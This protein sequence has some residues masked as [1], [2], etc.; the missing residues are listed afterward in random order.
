[1]KDLL[2]VVC[3]SVFSANISE[4]SLAKTSQ[5]FQEEQIL[6]VSN[7]AEPKDLDPGIATGIPEGHIIDTLFQGL[8]DVGPFSPDPIPGMAESWTISPDGLTY[9]F[10]IRKDA[11]WSDGQA[12]TADDFV[13]SWRR[14]LD[15]KTA[16]EY[17]YQLYYIKNGEAFN[18]GQI[19]DANQLGVHAKDALTLEVVL[20][21]PTP[22]FLQLTSFM[23]LYPVPKHVL[24]KYSGSEWTKENRLVSNGAFKLAEYR[25][26]QHIKLVKNEHFWDKA[27]IKPET[28]YI[29]PIENK[30][31]EEK[32]F[33]SGKIH[34]TSTVPAMRLPYYESQARENTSDH[35]PLK[36]E[37][38]FGT[39]YYRFNTSKK[40]LNDPR[41]RRALTLTVDRKE[42]VD[43]I[44]RGGKVPA[45]SFT[46]PLGTFDFR[47]S[48]PT[49][50]TDADLQE[51]KT[52]L[53]QAGYPEGKNMPKLN[54]LY[55][56][57]EDNKRIAIAIQDMWHKHL[58]IKV[59]IY[60]EEWKV[61]LESLRQLNFDI[62]RSRWIGDY[63]DPN[64]FL[65]LM[66]TN[67]GNN[68]TAW[69]NKTYD[70]TIK[71]ASVSQ[72]TIERGSLFKKAEDILMKEV[73]V[74]PVFYYTNPHLLSPDLKLFNPQTGEISEW[75][76]DP[77]D[78]WFLRYCV[79]LK[80][81]KRE[82]S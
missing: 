82:A 47:G 62:A 40:P 11:K 58:G 70:E 22:Y 36:V 13:F 68:N 72:N 54:I 7:G 42:I 4:T 9:I 52:L 19:K 28:I 46:P 50:V 69:S 49:H 20:E 31:T 24:A 57:D 74:L 64:T 71:Q 2:W 66:V 3:F 80:S 16:S 29:Y 38:L 25:L 59:G 18:K 6:R 10:K 17:A 44:V 5:A 79:L 27:S 12:L 14:A 73:P 77:M 37:P 32:T 53:A 76:S 51:A 41:V 21:H 65:D 67:G 78:R 55:D 23:T 60:N 35:K 61:Y 56:T 63:A 30:Y 33:V 75:K 1:M 43:K 48:I 45:S 81:N 39:Y 26:H 8:T 15:P 34:L